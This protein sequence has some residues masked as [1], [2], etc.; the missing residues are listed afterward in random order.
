MMDQTQPNNVTD[1]QPHPV[2][3]A[4]RVGFWIGLLVLLAALGLGSMA[5][6]GK[7]VS[8]RVSAQSTQVSQQLGEQFAL[9]Q[10]DMDAGRYS[11]ASQRLEYII[12]QDASF[13]GAADKLAEVMVKQLITPSPVP[14]DTPTITPTPDLRSQE[15]VFAQATK[16]L[17]EKDWSGLMASLDTLRKADPTYKAVLVDGMYYTALRNRG[18]DQIMGSA[19]YKTTNMEGGIY[20]LTLAE[21]FGPLDGYADGLRNFTRMYIIGAS[22]WDVNWQQAVE[23]FRQVYQFTPNLRD[24][25]NVTAGQRLNQALLSYGDQVAAKSKL[26]D[27]CQALDLWTEAGKIVALDGVYSTKFNQL[28]QDCNPP[29]EVPAA[30]DVPAV[31][32]DAAQPTTE[33]PTAEP[34]T[35]VPPTE[36]PPPGG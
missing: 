33:P 32:T 9:V 6:Y 16:Q 23:Y 27:R 25:S 17:A 18:V 31:P 10:A 28:Y 2:K 12:K 13:P 3:K 24:A 15:A 35:A 19:T 26:N 20:D 8:E 1:T 11:V 29:T 36:T 34:P 5:G 7:G 14:T 22:F 21:R 4:P 30:T